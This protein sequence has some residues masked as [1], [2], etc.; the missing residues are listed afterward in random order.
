MQPTNKQIQSKRFQ[1]KL[2]LIYIS[3]DANYFLKRSFKRNLIHFHGK[4]KMDHVMIFTLICF[5][6]DPIMYI[7]LQMI[8]KRSRIYKQL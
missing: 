4:E 3:V 1:I 8:Q 5:R 6:L 2:K 7:Y